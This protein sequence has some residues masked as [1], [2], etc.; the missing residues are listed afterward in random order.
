MPPSQALQHGPTCPNR[1]NVALPNVAY[2]EG[3]LGCRRDK[4][5][6]KKDTNILLNVF[7]RMYTRRWL[8]CLLLSSYHFLGFANPL[9]KNILLTDSFIN[10]RR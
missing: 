7:T 10:A 2:F 6:K 3:V 8:K 5:R 4:P 9:Q 1:A